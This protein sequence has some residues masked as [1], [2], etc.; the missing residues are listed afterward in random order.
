MSGY[1][2]GCTGKGVFTTA[3]RDAEYARKMRRNHESRLAAYHC[4]HC[5]QWHIGGLE[6]R[7]EAHRAREHRRQRWDL[8]QEAR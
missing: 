6:E 8:R 7:G 1:R 2:Q 5:H 4:R 3:A